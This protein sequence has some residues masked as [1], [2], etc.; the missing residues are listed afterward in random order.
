MTTPH[1]TMGQKGL[2]ILTNLTITLLGG[3]CP[4][5]VNRI[6]DGLHFISAILA[7]IFLA[8]QLMIISVNVILR[9]FFNSGISWT[10]EIATNVLMTA[11]TFLS[12]AIGVKLDLHINVNLIPRR[13]PQWITTVLLKLKYL[14]LSTIGFVILYYGI[15]LILGIRGRIASIPV[16]PAYLQFI[17]IP[18]AGV[19]ILYDSIMNLLGLEKDDAYLDRRLMSVGEKK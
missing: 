5:R 11:F 4:M 7:C 12:M 13:A 1:E 16:L 8:L 19:L 10:E 2:T 3:I 15:L 6:F 14:V 18:L 17:M 9:Y